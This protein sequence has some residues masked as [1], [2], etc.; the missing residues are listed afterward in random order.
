MPVY[1]GAHCDVL[2]VPSGLMMTGFAS[3]PGHALGSA[4]AT[5]GLCSFQDQKP[6]TGHTRPPPGQ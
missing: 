6:G 2:R 3:A 5:G 1:P 4:Q